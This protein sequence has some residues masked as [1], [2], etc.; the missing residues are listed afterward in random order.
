MAL[1]MAK[2][3]AVASSAAAPQRVGTPSRLASGASQPDFA[4]PEIDPVL[5]VGARAPDTDPNA[6]WRGPGDGTGGRREHTGRGNRDDAHGGVFPAPAI[7]RPTTVSDVILASQIVARRIGPP[8]MPRSE[9]TQA[10][11]IYDHA[12]QAVAGTLP[13][14]YL[15]TRLDVAL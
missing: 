7:V 14:T 12:I 2:P 10:V 15:G 4:V 5:G 1:Q 8:V 13:I 9:A 3:A 6:G 11:G